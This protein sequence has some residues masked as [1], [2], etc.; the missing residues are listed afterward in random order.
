MTPNARIAL[1]LLGLLCLAPA[2]G[3]AHIQPFTARDR[4]YEPGEYAALRAEARPSRGSIY[5]EAQA[6]YLEDT[7]GMRV[8]DIIMVRINENA[9]AQG[10]ATTNLK[11][12]SSRSAGIENLM[13]L[14]P[15]IKKAYPNIDPAELIKMASSFDFDGEGKTERAG[16]LSGLIGV[17][18]KQELP[19]GDLFMEGTKV[20]MINHEEYHL[21]VSGVVRPSD[22]A[23]DNSVDSSLIA[24]ARVEFTGR[25]DINDQVE[26]GWLNKILDFINPF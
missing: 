10:G 12:E 3:P 16:K 24:D 14:V 22:I 23:P 25:G 17:R 5:S 13:G 4:K 21:Y 26:R 20:V 19:N 15:A 18:V 6:G 8:G 2:C 7:R 1:A 11:K 9:Q